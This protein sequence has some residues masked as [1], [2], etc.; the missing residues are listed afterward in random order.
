MFPRF[1]PRAVQHL[2][3]AEDAIDRQQRGAGEIG[4]AGEADDLVGADLELKVAQLVTPGGSAGGGHGVADV[5]DGVPEQPVRKAKQGG[6]NVNGV[7]D[8]TDVDVRSAGLRP[9][10]PNQVE[11]APENVVVPIELARA[12]IAEVR[13][14]DGSGFDGALEDFRRG[15]RVAEADLMPSEDAS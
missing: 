9:G 13:E 11:D 3:G 14:G 12:R 8:Q 10:A 6:R 2:C 7:G 15:V 4:A 5:E 1:R